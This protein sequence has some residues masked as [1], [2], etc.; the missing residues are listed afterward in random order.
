MLK[1]V[2]FKLIIVQSAALLFLIHGIRSLYLAVNADFYLAITNGVSY[3]IVLPPSQTLE[4]VFLHHLYWIF[5]SFIFGILLIGLINWRSK[6]RIINTLLTFLI[7]FVLFPLGQFYDGF[8]PQLFNTFC[9]LFSD[10]MGTAFYTGGPILVLIAF[11]FLWL[12]ITMHRK[13]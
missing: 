1:K 5:G 12:G 2:N 7:I 13:S 10:N 3:D 8:I 6:T 9:Y 11:T 4:E